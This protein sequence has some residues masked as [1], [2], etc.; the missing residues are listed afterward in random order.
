MRQA[1]IA[2]WWGLACSTTAVAAPVVIWTTELPDAKLL[3]RAEKEAGEG[4]THLSAVELV[5][6][7]D[8]ERA[9]DM[10][11]LQAVQDAVAAGR[12]RWD[13]FEIELPIAQDIQL[14]LQDVTLLRDA[15]DV[16]ELI[17][18]LLFQGAAVVRAFEPSDFV[19]NEAAQPFR[20]SWDDQALPTPWLTAYALSRAIGREIASTD[21][22]D[23]TARRDFARFTEAFEALEPA[24]LT[25]PK[26]D[27][28][29]V[30]GVQVPSDVD[31]LSLVPG[32]HWMHLVRDGQVAAR[33][34]VWAEP[35]GRVAFPRAVAK[36]QLDQTEAQVEAGSK[37]DFPAPVVEAL[38]SLA[39]QHG[40]EV[41][42]ATAEGRKVHLVAW[43]EG[44]QLVDGQLV[45]V[46]ISGE[47]G[48]GI[49]SSSL[50]EEVDNDGTLV[51]A[52]HAG[53]AVELGVS[54][55]AAGIGLDVAATPGRTI[56]HA[57]V[58][59]NDNLQSSVL[60]QPWV[61]VGVHALRPVGN[62]ATLT[63]LGHVAWNGPAHIGYGGRLHLGVPVGK[64]ATWFRISTGVSYA[65]R[66]VWRLEEDPV[67]MLTGF[68]RIGV[69][70]RL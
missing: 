41:F 35:G 45:T 9:S 49:V 28:A 22:V 29:W 51:G 1:M 48:G 62:R 17:D 58:A 59:G 65:P 55:F 26:V 11:S 46:V 5:Y 10:E 67:P 30:D 6:P 60:P 37:T 43:S 56:L 18:A 32:W 66:T 27:E 53:L 68:L 70:A 69:A 40:G 15:R 52:A 57:N 3:A 19:V 36:A 4:V 14:T 47:T 21:H 13:E 34:R 63:I 38:E 54:H 7:L 44:A 31:T 39:E 16:S 8:P 64:D 61:G 33:G 50:F 12:A 24:Q 42:V 2:L 23:G 25:V 20:T